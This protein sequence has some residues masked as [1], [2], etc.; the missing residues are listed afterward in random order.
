M[1]SFG[2][3]ATAV[4]AV[5]AATGIMFGIGRD[6]LGE[7]VIALLYLLPISWST[8]RWGQGAGIAAAVAAALA[9]NFFFIPPYYTFVIGRL[10][11]WLLLGIFLAVAIVVVGRIQYGL[12]Q[13][14]ARERD[15]IF[16]YELSA[17]LASARSPQ[18]SARILAEKIQEL[19]R[20]ALVEVFV[21]WNG[22]SL[23][24]SAP[25]QGKFETKPDLILPVMTAYRLEGEIRIW[26]GDVRLPPADNRLLQN[27]ANQGALAFERERHAQGQ[28]HQKIEA[29]T[30]GRTHG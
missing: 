9:F 28:A 21:E 23:T 17:A 11:G 12:T 3:I 13:A 29:S 2:R 14:H 26:Q 27:F 25:P 6:R 10:E 19:F 20:A 4:L 8:A 5:A 24:V 18:A 15:A 16:M 30:Q 1:Q 22:G 7:G